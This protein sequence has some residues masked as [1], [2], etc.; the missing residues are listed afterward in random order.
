MP[1]AVRSTPAFICVQAGHC[2]SR[3]L[4]PSERCL[5]MIAIQPVNLPDEFATYGSF[6]S[7]FQ[8][9]PFVTSYQLRLGEQ[10]CGLF[11]R[12]L[13]L[14]AYNPHLPEPLKRRRAAL[15]ALRGTIHSNPPGSPALFPKERI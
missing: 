3:D 14:G 9:P 6:G 12:F 2:W 10:E 7:R 1:I 11:P 15:Q 13:F 5:C 4:S 8:R